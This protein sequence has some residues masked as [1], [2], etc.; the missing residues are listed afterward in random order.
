MGKEKCLHKKNIVITIGMSRDKLSKQK[1]LENNNSDNNRN[2][3][4]AYNEMQSF[5]LFSVKKNID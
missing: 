2:D 5:Y 1:F 4:N 3:D